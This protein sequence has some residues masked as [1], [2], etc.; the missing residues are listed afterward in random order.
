M[1]PGP[2]PEFGVYLLP[3]DPGHFPWEHRWVRWRDFRLPSSDAE[4]LAALGEA[5]E[6]APHQR[7]EVACR[8]GIGRTGTALAAMA[9]WAGIPRSDAVTWVRQ[10][11]QRRSVETPRQRRWV[12]QLVAPDTPHSPPTLP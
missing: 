6:R 8:G 2:D 11:Y 5:F 3:A 12:R 10:H 4:A 1:A 9:V 7:V